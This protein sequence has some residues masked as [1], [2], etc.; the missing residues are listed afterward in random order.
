MKNLIFILLFLCIISESYSNQFRNCIANKILNIEKQAGY[1]IPDS[2]YTLLDTILTRAVSEINPKSNYSKEDALEILSQIAEIHHE[3]GI[4]TRLH[5]YGDLL[6]T[7]LKDKMFDCGNY[8]LTYLSIAEMLHLPIYAV[9]V[10][11]HIFLHFNDS[12]TCSFFW[13]TLYEYEG[14]REHYISSNHIN[15]E[16]IEKGIYLKDLKFEE[17]ISDRYVTLSTILRKDNKFQEAI[18][19]GEEAIKLNPKN[20][21]AYS[22]LGSDF[23]GMKNF[24]KAMEFYKK[25]IEL[26]NNWVVVY[27][28]IGSMFLKQKM[29]DSALV[30]VSRAI[31]IDS[32]HG[33]S[34]F[35][36]SLIYIHFVEYE[37]ALEDINRV[38]EISSAIDTISANTYSRKGDILYRLE[39]FEEAI[40]QYSNSI[41]S[42]ANNKKVYNNR[43]LA[44]AQIQDYDNASKDWNTV[45]QLD[46]IYRNAYANLGRYYYYIADD[47]KKAIPELLQAVKLDTTVDYVYYFLGL[48]FYY[49]DRY[50]ESVDWFNKYLAKNPDDIDAY[51]DR[52]DSYLE[53]DECD[54]ALSDYQRLV[55]VKG[56]NAT[57]DNIKDLIECMLCCNKYDRVE[58]LIDIGIQK[59]PSFKNWKLYLFYSYLLQN[60][61]DE[62]KELFEKYIKNNVKIEKSGFVDDLKEFKKTYPDN[63]NIDDYIEKI[64]K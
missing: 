25:A 64:M 19:Y 53:L 46:S 13:E 11:G 33:N 51:K 60:R 7:G 37:K 27:S 23:L 34:Y 9:D 40:E 5:L 28:N 43:G 30:Y 62:A 63:K 4:E 32:M 48:S 6:V 29:Y 45:I 39:R 31:S 56:D 16:T 38:I 14:R 58:K 15:N 59:E 24:D 10:P 26:N 52:G 21:S 20:V 47:N 44:Y 12:D 41:K 18:K 1:A 49:T 42:N 57:K 2:A 3:L 55:D 54:S 35:N 61:I 8:V 50:R 22:S 17:L 36:R